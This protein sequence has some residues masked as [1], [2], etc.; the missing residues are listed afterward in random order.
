MRKNTSERSGSSCKSIQFH[1]GAKSDVMLFREEQLLN[2]IHT[3]GQT[4][5]MQYYTFQDE[6]SYA[7]RIEIII[8]STEKMA[9]S[10]QYK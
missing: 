2:E 7:P 1:V 8:G 4:A 3:L 10:Y 9:F 5:A 6:G